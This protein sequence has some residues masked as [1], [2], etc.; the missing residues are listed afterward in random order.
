MKYPKDEFI[1]LGML[2]IYIIS[3][4]VCC[5]LFAIIYTA[6]GGR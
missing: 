1:G 4:T 3:T 5:G 6:L 2:M